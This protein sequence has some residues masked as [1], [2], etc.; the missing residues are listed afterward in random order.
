[1]RKTKIVC[2]IGPASGSLEMVKQLLQAGMDVARLNFSH[3]SHEEHAARPGNLALSCGGDGQ[4]SGD[5][6]GYQGAGD[7]YRFFK[8]RQGQP[9]GWRPGDSDYRGD[10]G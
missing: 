8:G 9:S 5:H 2:T 1:M 6:A 4:V 7:P 10:R 3:G